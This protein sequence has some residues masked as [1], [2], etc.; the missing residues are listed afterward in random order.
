MLRLRPLARAPLRRYFSA[1]RMKDEYGAMSDA[2]D[3]FEHDGPFTLEVS[4][5][6]VQLFSYPNFALTT[7]NL[8]ELL[9]TSP[10]RCVLQACGTPNLRYLRGIK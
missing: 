8:A 4:A 5:P 2:G 1:S 3:T 7:S 9:M 6:Q 10:H